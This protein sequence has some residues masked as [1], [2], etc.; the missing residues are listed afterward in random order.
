MVRNQNIAVI[1][2]HV[3]LNRIAL[4]VAEFTVG[5]TRAVHL[6][7]KSLTQDGVV[8]LRHSN[9]IDKQ[10]PHHSGLLAADID[11]CDR[12]EAAHRQSFNYATGTANIQRNIVRAPFSLT[13][14]FA[15]FLQHKPPASVAFQCTT[16]QQCFAIGDKNPRIDVFTGESGRDNDSITFAKRLL[17]GGDPV[18]IVVV[19]HRNRLAGRRPCN[20]GRQQRHGCQDG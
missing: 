10:V 13:D 20:A 11:L 15:A 2:R 16:D 14:D 5:N 19:V 4:Q 6:V 1:D 18:V 9:V 12:A 3:P 17:K 8:S 7:M